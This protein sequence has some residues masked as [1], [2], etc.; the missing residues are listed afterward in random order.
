VCDDS[1]EKTPPQS[2]LHTP[3]LP[4][5]SRLAA[6]SE[7]E[8]IHSLRRSNSNDEDISSSRS[9]SPDD[10]P[11]DPSFAS[12]NMDNA[13][14]LQS[15]SMSHPIAT[16]PPAAHFATAAAEPEVSSLEN[17]LCVIST[18]IQ[19]HPKHS[20][21]GVLLQSEI[22]RVREELD[23]VDNEIS[24]HAIHVIAP[25]G[26][27]GLVV[28]KHPDEGSVYIRWLHPLSPVQNQLQLKDKI[29]AIDDVDVQQLSPV[30]VGMLL[31]RTRM[32]ERRKISIIR[33]VRAIR[34]SRK[35]R[36]PEIIQQEDPF[37]MNPVNEEAGDTKNDVSEQE[38]NGTNSQKPKESQIESTPSKAAFDLSDVNHFL[39][40]L[41]EQYKDFVE[42]SVTGPVP[43][44]EVE[45][46]YAER[47]RKESTLDSKAR[48]SSEVILQGDP[49]GLSPVEE[50]EEETE[51]GH[52]VK[53]EAVDHCDVRR[54]R[55]EAQQTKAALLP[56][57]YVCHARKTPYTPLGPSGAVTDEAETHGS[58]MA[59][60]PLEVLKLLKQIQFPK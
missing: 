59:E 48:R 33:E 35:R 45:N 42:K 16:L 26:N 49:S 37:G 50:E 54:P 60:S 53:T 38:A 29:I 43:K 39:G 22:D 7:Q 23:E 36:A 40:E 17:E 8:N 1:A 2:Q 19:S 31:C 18:A 52:S 58:T 28:D 11:E 27:L 24:R 47:C 55:S 6:D 10:A 4:P 5:A 12:N 20:E 34:S 30:V 57:S 15:Q 41:D 46:W 25:S 21:T 9:S 13:T 32:N 44:A 14:P 56:V 3:A 51:N